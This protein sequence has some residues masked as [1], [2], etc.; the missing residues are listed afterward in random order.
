MNKAASILI[1]VLFA[2]VVLGGL[3]AVIGGSLAGA[4]MFIVGLPFAFPMSISLFVIF[5]SVLI[6]R[7]VIS[8]RREARELREIL[9]DDDKR[10]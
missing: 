10:E 2:I 9:E 1:A 7:T 4:L 8:K 6:L 3:I 5:F